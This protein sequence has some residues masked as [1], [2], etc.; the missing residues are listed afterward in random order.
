MKLSS[1]EKYGCLAL[2]MIPGLGKQTFKK[3]IDAFGS[4]RAVFEAGSSAL[5]QVNGIRRDVVEKILK[6]TFV[7]DPEEALRKTELAG[8]RLITYNDPLYPSFLREITSPPM[9]L[10]IRGHDIPQD[11]MLI[12]VVG[13]RNATS[14]GLKAAQ[15]IGYGLAK[16]G[17]GVVSG[18]ARGIDSAAH[19]GCL[20]ADGFTV[21]VLGTGIDLVYPSSNKNL[22]EQI[23]AT[24]AVISE[25]PIGA[26]PEPKNFPIRNR[27]I[28]GVSR[29]VVVV[30]ATQKSGSLITA[31]F[32]LD[33]NREVFGVPGSI[34]SFKSVGTHL[35]IK[36]GAKLVENADDILDDFGLDGKGSGTTDRVNAFTSGS[37][38]KI[39]ESEQKTYDLIGDYP[40]HID[41]IVRSRKINPGEALGVLMKME[42]EG[43][44]IQL[45]GNMFV[46]KAQNRLAPI[47][48]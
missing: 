48:K 3:L 2:S 37:A 10:F 19:T 43:L 45:P 29:G 26:R 13:S 24:G 25:F 40:V 27:I 18:L 22:M 30:E 42:L 6:K 31:R 28:S 15:D 47:H 44:I 38:I 1:D 11:L 16:R 36:Q 9:L 5:L 32:A 34:H 33:Q 35:L 7:S 14:Y 21:A 8:A 41:H 39:T 20:R 17:V 12:G 46:R 23:V 4:T